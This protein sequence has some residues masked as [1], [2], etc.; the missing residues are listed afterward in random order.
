MDLQLEKLDFSYLDIWLIVFLT[1][2]ITPLE[3]EFTVL[4]HECDE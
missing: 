4:R 3:R 1:G 2:W